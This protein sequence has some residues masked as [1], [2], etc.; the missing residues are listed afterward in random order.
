MDGFTTAAKPS[1]LARGFFLHGLLE[2]CPK[3]RQGA[4]GIR[5]AGPILERRGRTLLAGA[6]LE[7]PD[8]SIAELDS[9]AGHLVASWPRTNYIRPSIDTMTARPDHDRWSSV[10]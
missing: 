9:H 7:R 3:L 4:L 6:C 1:P 8:F 2:C 10:Q 5:A